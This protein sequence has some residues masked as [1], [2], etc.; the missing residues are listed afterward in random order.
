MHADLRQQLDHSLKDLI[1]RYASFVKCILTSIEQIGVSHERLAKYLLSIPAFTTHPGKEEL[2]LFSN[3]KDEF[4]S[5]DALS[6]I[7]ITLS[8]EY[9]SFLNPDVFQSIVDEFQLQGHEEKLE[10]M[11]YYWPYAHM[12]KLSE[13]MEVNPLSAVGTERAKKLV[14][15]FDI[16]LA[17]TLARLLELKEGLARVLGLRPIT[18]R[19]K[20]VEEGCVI[21]SFLIP[22]AVANFLFNK[23]TKFGPKKVE[24]IRSLSIQMIK[25]ND[26]VFDF[27]IKAPGK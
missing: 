1:Y 19:L 2:M 18:I 15:K 7:F 17:S 9:A 22:T 20:L 5:A 6:R 21:V 3:L 12:H 4:E 16:S 13:F 27:R 23:D 26:F 10:Y 25:C 14:V 8:I 11:E 24:E